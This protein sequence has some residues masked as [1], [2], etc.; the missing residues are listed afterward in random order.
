MSD[1]HRLLIRGQS[2]KHMQFIEEMIEELDKQIREKLAPPVPKAGGI[3]LCGVPGIGSDA[4]ASILA[5]IGMDMSDNG[6]F[7]SCHHLA[8]WAGVCPGNASSAG[9]RKSG[10]VR[11]GNRWLKA[12]LTQNRIGWVQQ[13]ELCISVPLSAI[14]DATR[15]VAGKPS[16]LVTPNSSPCI[17]CFETVFLIN[18]NAGI[19]NGNN[20]NL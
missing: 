4:A 15:C 16:L 17:G 8:S 5:E 9:E 3:G 13:E 20:G 12:T 1:H 2:L 6:P 18:N 7:S 19:S 14:E 10:R 11:K